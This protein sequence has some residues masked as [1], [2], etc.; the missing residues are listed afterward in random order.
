MIKM[1]IKID[2]KLPPRVDT[3]EVALTCPK[4]K[5]KNK[6]TMAQVKREETVQCVGCGTKIKLIDEGKSF[7]QGTE[8][9]Q[10][11]LDD[12]ERTVR[13]FGR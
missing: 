8:K 13:R 10:R 12:L 5:A 7:K 9:L 1:R 3:W 2:V 11:A 6:V 4:C